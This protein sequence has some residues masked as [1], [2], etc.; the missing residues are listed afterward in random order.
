[1]ND[2]SHE[3]ERKFLVGEVPAN[4][5]GSP[6]QGIRQGYLAATQGGTELRVREQ[7]QRHFLTLKE[8]HGESRVQ[9]EIEITASQFRALW[10]LTR[11]KRIKKVRHEVSYDG[12]T[13]EVD[14]YRGKLKG[15]VVAE[16]EFPDLEASHRF[17]PPDWLGREVT[18]DD[19]YSNQNL[20]R[21]GLALEVG[22]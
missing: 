3:I 11:G 7:G 9:E 8:G 19:H 4:L 21:H 12:R 18:G 10:P 16:V 22:C 15:L 13:I 17:R 6:G 14:V 1:M 20:A 2:R 5:E